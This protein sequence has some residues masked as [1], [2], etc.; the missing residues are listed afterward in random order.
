MDDLLG[1]VV[2][3]GGLSP[4]EEGV[5]HKVRVGVLPQPLVGGQ[6]VQGVHVLALVLVQALDLHIEQGR[7]VHNVPLGLLQVLG[8]PL[9]VGLLDLLQLLQHRGVLRIFPQ[10]LQLIRVVDIVFSDQVG[11]EPGQLG[12]GLVQPPPVGNAVGHIGEFRGL[13]HIEV[14]NTSS[15]KISLCRA[16]T[17]LTQ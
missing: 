2:A 1:K 16:E 8:Q 17:P 4:K 5:G 3:R 12:V 15:F 13:L 9:L 11:D 14:G 6:D 7:G 10:A